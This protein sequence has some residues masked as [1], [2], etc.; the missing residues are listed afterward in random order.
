M[1]IDAADPYGILITN[2]EF[3]AFEGPNPTEVVG[4]LLSP[5]HTPPSSS[6]SRILSSF[7]SSLVGANNTGKVQFVN[8]AFWGPGHQIAVLNGSGTVGFV[9][10]TFCQWNFDKTSRSVR[11]RG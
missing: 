9:G 2:G 4:M 1:Q 3:T 7:L 5:S 10:C 11:V 6:H 8:T